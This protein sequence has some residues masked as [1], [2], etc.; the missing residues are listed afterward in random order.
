MQLIDRVK[1]A[2]S[3]NCGDSL[4]LL[5]PVMVA[6]TMALLLLVPGMLTGL[7]KK[8]LKNGLYG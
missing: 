1:R 5:D 2:L 6:A 7:Q 3:E 4:H 8:V